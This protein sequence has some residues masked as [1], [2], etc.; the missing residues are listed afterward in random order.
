MPLR[1]GTLLLAWLI[2]MVL[3]GMAHGTSDVERGVDIPIVFDGVPEDLV[4]VG[5]AVRTVNIRVLGSRAALREVGPTR[6]EYRVDVSDAQPGD[7]VYEIDTGRI[8]DQLPRGARIVS[9]SPASL[10]LRFAR[11][12]RK[13]MPV[14]ADVVGV[15]STGYTISSIEVD[16]P[17]VWLTGAAREVLR[18]REAVTETVDV[19]NLSAPLEREVRLSLGDHV[20][21]EE[22]RTV[23]VRVGIEPLPGGAASRERPAQEGS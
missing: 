17:Q 23:R 12:G 16:P 10:E 6:I 3:W 4:M 21:M 1:I 22:P 5:Q 18:L 9:R 11:R 2:A 14:R 20:W 19:R 7:A 8:E 13:A 15:P